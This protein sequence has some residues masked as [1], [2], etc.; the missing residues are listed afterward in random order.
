MKKICYSILYLSLFAYLAGC[1][2]DQ[3]NVVATAIEL[4]PAE[5]NI[6]ENE[7]AN[8]SLTPVPGGTAS[9]TVESKP[10]W[11]VLSQE[12]GHLNNS[13]TTLNL[14]T[15]ESGLNPGTYSGD[16]KISSSAGPAFAKINFTIDA[17]PEA[18]L[19]TDQLNFDPVTEVQNFTL[20]NSGTGGLTWTAA[21]EASWMTIT[22]AEG[23]ISAS[24][25]MEIEVVVNRENLPVGTQNANIV[26]SSNADHGDVLL[27][28]TM[29]VPEIA[30]IAL[31]A[32]S[33]GVDFF[34]ENNTVTI[35]NDGNVTYDYSITMDESFVTLSPSTGTLAMGE[36]VDVTITPDRTALSTGT[37]TTTLTISNNKGESVTLPV[38]VNHFIEE[39]LLI[40]G[41]LKDA[42]YDRNNDVFILAFDK[43]LRKYNPADE[44]FTSVALN[45]ASNCVSVSLDGRYA[46]VGHTGFISYVDLSTM[47]L[48]ETY[49]VTTDVFDIV[50]APNGYVYA[51]PEE[52]QW[53]K[54]R[55]LNL[56]DGTETLSGVSSIYE[57]TRAK[58]HPSG[59]YIY[60]ANNGLSPS[61]FEKY[62][63]TGGTASY[64]YDSPYHGDFEFRGNI[65]IS[66]DGTRLFSRAMNVFK[67]TT[68]KATDMTY[69]GALGEG[70]FVVALDHS[71]LINKVYAVLTTGNRYDDI[72]SSEVSVYD[73][74]YYQL[75]KTISLPK[76]IIADGT[77]G[78]QLYDSQ[79]LFGF[80]NS[81]G[82]S[83]HTVVRN[84]G[85]KN[86]FAIVSLPVQ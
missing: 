80:F 23:S 32:D 52:D 21:T 12:S 38:S 2:D 4:S 43:E 22:P 61:D 67:S 46:V 44:S 15:D 11:L 37:S 70:S 53:E 33:V 58:L 59:N 35:I 27:P 13:P 60:G 30:T 31:S 55:C 66:D 10:S 84:A 25:N 49:S 26:I 69:A 7:T 41:I 71:S 74:T 29:E 36:T 65:W 14:T 68:D 45:L 54:I 83:Y 73:G 8:L 34:V 28:V 62:D 76:F 3:E 40:S 39:K 42:E 79:G 48:L 78:G 85:D 64:M 19:S 47:T 16:L 18:Q 86:S 17:H 51:F 5:V 77:G 1:S 50:L 63:I 24:G 81:A 20:T 6:N 72:P 82:T 56:S 57:N 9:W 75:E